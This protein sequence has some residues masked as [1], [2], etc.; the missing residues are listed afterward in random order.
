M[1]SLEYLA[2][3]PFRAVDWR[4][5]R[6]VEIVD[7]NGIPATRRKDEPIGYKWINKAVRFNAALRD[8]IDSDYR[9]I[10]LSEAEPDIFW[11]WYMWERLRAMRASVEARIL[12]RCTNDEVGIHCGIPPS[13]IEAFEALFFNVRE[14][15]YHRSYILHCVI[16]PVV[17]RGLTDREYDLLW[18]LYGYFL[19]PHVVNALESQFVDASWCGTPDAV[20][21][22]LTDDAIST[23]KLKAALATKTVAVNTHTQ[24]ALM[25]QFS[26]FVEIERTTDSSGKAQDQILDHVSALMTTLPFNVGGRD[27]RGSVLPFNPVQGYEKTAMELTYEETMRVSVNQTI[28]HGDVLK[29]LEFP[30][31]ESTQKIEDKR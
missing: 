5:Q 1:P 9:M 17:S 10:E 16:K 12:A 18:K 14:K 13:Y 22:A 2:A 6:A 24:L 28:L 3:N 20:H 25:D 30:V 21:S 27:P 29:K 19:G 26:K 8:S 31:T 4:W 15:M 23:M 7:G 11:A